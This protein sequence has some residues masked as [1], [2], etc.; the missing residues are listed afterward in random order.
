MFIS[1][2]ESIAVEKRSAEASLETRK[3]SIKALESTVA[4]LRKEF[5]GRSSAVDPD[6]EASDLVKEKTPEPSHHDSRVEEL[7]R[8]IHQTVTISMFYLIG[9]SYKYISKD[10]G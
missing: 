5:E 2:V 10:I 4:E 7:R 1:K 3:D 9:I 8:K 6:G